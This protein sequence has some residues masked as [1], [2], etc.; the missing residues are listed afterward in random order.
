MPDSTIAAVDNAFIYIM[1]FAFLLFALIVFLTIYFAI[2][3]RRSRNPQPADI[4]GNWV[5]ELVWIVA[6]TLLVLTM[7][8]YGLTGFNFLRHAPRDAMRVKVTARQWSW[9]FEY[10]N[11]KRST[12][13]VAPQGSAVALDMV[14]LDVIHSFFAPAYRI[15][16]DVVPGL[17]T[18]VWFRAQILGLSDVLCAEYCGLEHSKMQ[19]RIVVTSPG[20]FAE[21]YAGRQES[22]PELGIDD[23]PVA[24]RVLREHG[25]LD[26][27]SLDATP[28]VG[29]TFK[30]LYG[31]TVSVVTAGKQRTVVA[32]DEYLGRSISDPGADITVGFQS[33]MPA[34]ASKDRLTEEQVHE[35]LEY[36]M[37]LR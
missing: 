6:A 20:D 10:D 8:F 18:H 26:C 28:S 5:L 4:P 11:G 3:Y 30:G 22:V 35:V 1:A 37:T 34:A 12:D 29:P 13:L 9:L 24:A 2:R 17:T 32:D 7:F 33:I 25:C 14:S 27:H 15:K 19:S 23:L 36:L 31:S 16:Q 21:W